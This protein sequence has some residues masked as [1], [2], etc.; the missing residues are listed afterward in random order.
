[1]TIVLDAS[2]VLSSLRDKERPVED[3]LLPFMPL[4]VR[5]SVMIAIG[6]V[7]DSA[8]CPSKY[9]M[10]FQS[11]LRDN[12]YRS[13]RAEWRLN[14]GLEGGHWNGIGYP[15]KNHVFRQEWDST[16]LQRQEERIRQ[17][18]RYCYTAVVVNRSGMCR[19]EASSFFGGG[20]ELSWRPSS[21]R[22][23]SVH[24]SKAGGSAIG[25]HASCI[26][27]YL[28]STTVRR[29]SAVRISIIPR[30]CICA[31]HTT[32]G[33]GG[34]VTLL[35]RT[36]NGGDLRPE[37]PD[38]PIWHGVLIQL[39]IPICRLSIACFGS[40]AVDVPTVGKVGGNLQW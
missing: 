9:Y 8:Y 1:M 10:L 21:T 27:D 38:L 35:H 26:T 32:R 16:Y 19:Y 31:Y 39:K 30:D 29:G 34:L 2:N 6:A 37:D 23:V 13:E 33:L 24:D 15:T 36:V 5:P 28:R 3:R 18:K 14:S 7:E 22:F 25:L 12:L 4:R 40:I 20:F 17:G 11:F